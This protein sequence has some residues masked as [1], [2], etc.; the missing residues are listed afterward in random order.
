MPSK[1]EGWKRCTFDARST[2]QSSVL[3]RIARYC[4]TDS[5]SPSNFSNVR[6]YATASEK[7]SLI[8][9]ATAS[10][11]SRISSTTSG[12]YCRGAER[13]API[14]LGSGSPLSSISSRS[15]RA[16]NR[17]FRLANFPNC[18]CNR[19]TIIFRRL[20]SSGSGAA[21]GSAWSSST[22]S[23][24]SLVRSSTEWSPC[25][26]HA[27][28]SSCLRIRLVICW[29]NAKAL[30]NAPPDRSVTPQLPAVTGTALPQRDGRS[31]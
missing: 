15:I 12:S 16:A 19:A 28:R 6:M 11:L 3:I 30:F 4:A 24:V 23:Q 26:D 29:K 13:R 9:R 10:A 20:S 5:L 17:S 7:H 18:R 31:T 27:I 8:T 2:R 21:S 1:M 25:D 14:A 22:I